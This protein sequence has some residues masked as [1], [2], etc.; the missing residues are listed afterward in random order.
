MAD[1]VINVGAVSAITAGTGLTGGTVTGTGTIAADFGTSAGTICQGNDSRLT[2][3]RTPTTHAATH[4][5]GG[6]D[7]VTLDQ[8]QITSLTTDLAAKVA[9]T[10]QVIAGTGMS[11]GGALSADV[12]LNVSYGS[13]GTTA[14]VGNDARLSNARTP[15]PHSASHEALGSDALTLSKSQITGLTAD[16]AAKALGATT[17]TAG[18]G[19]TGGG[20]LSANRSFAVAYGTTSTT[21][22]VG[23]DARLSFTAAGTGATSRTLQNKLRDMVSVKDFGAVGDGATDDRAAIQAAIDSCITLDRTLFFP[24]G[25]YVMS[26]FT[27]SGAGIQ[28]DILTPANALRMEAESATIKSTTTTQAAFMFYVRGGESTDVSLKG[29]TFDANLKSQV[30]FR[31]DEEDQG[32]TVV[33]VDNCVFQNGYGIETGVPVGAAFWR[34]SGGFELNGGYKF[35]NVT[36]SSFTNFKRSALTATTS[37]ETFGMAV[38]VN[39]DPSLTYPQ[40]T[41]V[42]GCYFNDI[43]NNQTADVAQNANADGLKIFGGVTSGSSY[44]ASTATIS[45]NHFINCQGRAVKVQNDETVITGNT[46]RYAVQPIQGGSGQINCQLEC[47]IVSNNVFHY[48]VGPGA[49]NPFANTPSAFG[50]APIGFYSGTATTRARMYT[51]TDNIVL[52]NVPEATGVLGS[53]A[54]WTEA[55]ETALPVFVT[56]TGNKI[57]GPLKVFASPTLRDSGSSGVCSSVIKNNMMTKLVSA[58]LASNA[59]GRFDI[60]KFEVSGNVNSTAPAVAHLVSNSNFTTILTA[61]FN[62]DRN[63]NIGLT[64]SLVNSNGAGFLPRVGTIVDPNSANGGGI[65]VQSALLADDATYAFPRSTYVANGASLRVLTSSFGG[66]TN[67]LFFHGTSTVTSVSAGT[68]IASANTS[69]PNTDTKLNVWID[70]AASPPAINIKNRLGDSYVFTLITLG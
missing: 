51:I 2:N 19:L 62:A 45:N 58:F 31:H 8:S 7:P 49:T 35:I 29:L 14:C 69:N 53:F 6:G 23:N 46:V 56:V 36:N 21:A 64:A 61:D 16:L 4:A 47:G 57:S 50:S 25:V 3:G 18:T 24:S 1:I 37:F 52:N 22:T 11:G 40:N 26:S 67:F 5:T 48:D 39:T 10:R 70:T 13:S 42:S 27:N 66:T 55:A 41:N 12:T 20:D 38:G 68:D 60:N 43:N 32:V 17:M 54:G 33:E 44:T 65:T 30:C 63:Q 34:A 59:S 28:I 9:T 15:N